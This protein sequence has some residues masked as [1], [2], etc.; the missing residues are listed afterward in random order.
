VSRR[1]V[2]AARIRAL[3]LRRRLE[4]E[5]ADEIRFHLEMQADDHIRTGMDPRQARHAAARAFGGVSTMKETYRE[6]RT[7]H[8]IETIAQDIRYAM[9]LM[10]KSPGFTTVAVLSLAIGIGANTAVFSA[11]DA[12]LIRP[13]LGAAARRGADRRID[14][15]PPA[16][17][18]PGR[19]VSRLC[20]C[21]G[22]QHELRGI[23]RVH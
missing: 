4:R 3:F 8:P 9:R 18:R 10:R 5:L 19:L 23:G 20:R 11:A 17:R 14:V 2:L 22:S 7:F 13:L 1:S 21:P 15:S 16:V 6:R 12:H